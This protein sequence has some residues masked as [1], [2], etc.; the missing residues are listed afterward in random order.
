MRYLDTWNYP[1]PPAVT[2]GVLDLRG[3][4]LNDRQTLELNGEWMFFPGVLLMEKKSTAATD[5]SAPSAT[6][7][8]VPHV[9]D[10]SVFPHDAAFRYGSYRLTILPGDNRNQTLA[11]RLSRAGNASEVFVNGEP[12]GSSGRPA[13]DIIRHRGAD[14]PYTVLIPPGGDIVDIVIHVS[15]DTNDAGIFKPVRFGTY[16]AVRHRETLLIGLQLIMCSL[17]LFHGLYGIILY[18]L[19]ARSRATLYYLALMILLG[20]AALLSDDKLLFRLIDT[21]YDLQQLMIY[22]VYIG[23]LVC[24]PL[25]CNGLFPSGRGERLT[26]MYAVVCLLIAVCVILS[27]PAVEPVIRLLARIVYFASFALTCY[28]LIRNVRMDDGIPYLLIACIAVAVNMIWA[29]AGLDSPLMEF[30]WYPFDLM[31]AILAFSAFWFKRMFRERELTL[32]LADRLREEDRRKD[33]FLVNTSHE[34]RNPLQGITNILQVVLDDRNDPVSRRQR[35]RIEIARRV[36]RRMSA[37]LDDLIDITRLKERTVPLHLRPIHLQSVAAGLMDMVKIMLEGKPV[38]LEVD[39]DR[40]FP[41]VMAD[42]TRLAQIL[43]NLLHNAVKYT[44]EGLIRVR[45]DRVG[46]MAEI[47]VEDTGIGIA[48]EDLPHIFQPYEQSRHDAERSRG[49]FGLGLGICKQLVELHGG[50]IRAASRRDVGS[51][52]VF[53][54][55]LAGEAGLATEDE[56]GAGANANDSVTPGADDAALPAPAP[57]LIPPEP[58]PKTPVGIA[59]R[60]VAAPRLLLVDD[61][62]VNLRVLAQTLSLDGYAITGVTGAEQALE[63]LR[64]D[65]YALVVTDVMMPKVSGYELTRQIR[66][67]FN[68]TEL[69]VLLLTARTRAED[70]VAGFQAGANDYVKKPADAWELRSRVRSLVGL[71]SAFEDR[72]RMESAW[73]QSQIKPHFLYN[74]LNSIAAMGYTDFDKMQTLLHEF[75]RYLRLS[76]DFRNAAPLVELE[77]E[78]KLIR[79]YLHIELERFGDRIRVKWDVEGDI[80][81]MV[82][83]LSIQPL[84]E[85]AIKHGLMRRNEGGTV[86]I[87]IAKR[88]N[89]AEIAVSDDGVGMTGEQLERLLA[90][91]AQT[92]PGMSVGLRNIDRQLK[93]LFQDGLRVESAPDRGTVVRFRVPM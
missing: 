73:L 34:L 7:I 42:E 32:L 49:G 54:L 66:R 53:T 20:L 88:G 13:T 39:I 38:R 68:A 27:P 15:S 6:P 40:N 28:I 11:L 80:D 3:M 85:N 21:G 36:S 58:E 89:Q 62:A 59:G 37:M 51:V 5:T 43:F 78:L 14:L 8:R 84:V 31:F 19:G 90:E 56:A 92:G 55:P 30:I 64:K 4:K 50:T 33:E 76:F 48:E 44:D 18:C 86:T 52:F 87:S 75:S 61:D 24:L 10:G 65:R 82:P 23:M 67:R 63:S 41:Q 60:E 93:Q 35:E 83:P 25:L 69:P 74:T 46:Q 1:D 72:I 79:S 26:H 81:V 47:R 77:H 70:M 29:V 12:A 57:A 2:D 9:W 71:K 17:A 91:S 45:A 22:F 16:E